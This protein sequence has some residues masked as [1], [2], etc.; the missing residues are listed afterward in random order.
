VKWRY[1][2]NHKRLHGKSEEIQEENISRAIK[3]KSCN[4]VLL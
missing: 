1:E 4:H 2:A 3:V